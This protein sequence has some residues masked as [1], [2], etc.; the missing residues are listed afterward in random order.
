MLLELKSFREALT[1][2]IESSSKVFIVGHNSPDYDALGSAMG[3]FSYVRSFGKEAYIII[4]DDL[5]NL[6]SKVRLII[7]KNKE[8]CNMI[9]KE[10]Y[11]KLVDNDSLLIVTDTNRKYRIS[12]ND[13][14]DKFKNVFIIDHHDL[15]PTTSINTAYRLIDTT[16]SSASEMVAELLFSKKTAITPNVATMLLAG[17][18][19]DTKRF[20][21]NTTGRTFQ[22]SG[23]LQNRKADYQYVNSLFQ[24]DFETY[25]KVSNLVVNGPIFRRYILDD[26]EM[27]I[28]FNL[29]RRQNRANYTTID[30]AKTADAMLKFSD[31]TFAMGCTG[32]NQVTISARRGTKP[33][34]DVHHLPIELDVGKILMTLDPE[35]CGGNAQSAGGL[36]PISED[37]FK[38]IKCVENK[39]MSIVNKALITQG[40]QK[41]KKSK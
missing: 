41:V 6:D 36:I 3:L 21:R 24:E 23:M 5:D 30:V 9:T 14:L 38:S 17:I 15:D 40:Y 13:D 32:K 20:K 12:V 4:D 8:C 22:I 18:T 37:G 19:L 34:V 2:S 29:N 28:S 35:R 39:L 26:D 10:E 11:K 16:K 31:A 25:K 7:E 1:S 27:C 33:V